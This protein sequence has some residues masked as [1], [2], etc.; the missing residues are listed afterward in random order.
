M[1]IYV[2]GRSDDPEAHSR[3]SVDF[4]R[5]APEARRPITL[6]YG[7]WQG[8]LPLSNWVDQVRAVVPHVAVLP[9]DPPDPQHVIGRGTKQCCQITFG[10]AK[11]DIGLMSITFRV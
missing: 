6:P 5:R 4:V 1:R 9:I 3:K 10:F 7:A 8:R 11:P 2:D